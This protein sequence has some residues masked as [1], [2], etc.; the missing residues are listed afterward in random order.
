M[1]T[2]CYDIISLHKNNLALK[3]CP[4]CQADLH[5]R[6]VDHSKASDEFCRT[7]SMPVISTDLITCTHCNW[8]AV[9]EQREDRDLYY[10]PVDD[11]IILAAGKIDTDQPE[12]HPPVEKI[13][14]DQASWANPDPIPSTQAVQLFGT[15]Q[16]LLPA[17]T[18]SSSIDIWNKLKS[19]AP[20][21]LPVLFVILVAIF[22]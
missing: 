14:S 19:A 2:V 12:H 1:K 11:V 20:V 17:I 22:Y 8:W 13:L 5:H 7:A 4:A 6:E 15:V 9:R 10:P 3:T 18:R 21:L 16:M